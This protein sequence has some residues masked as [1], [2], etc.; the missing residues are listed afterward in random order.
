MVYD[1]KSRGNSRSEKELRALGFLILA[2]R[3]SRV[4]N[5]HLST[6]RIRL[7]SF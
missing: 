6:G 3:L 5:F 2:T 7:R 4:L 1:P